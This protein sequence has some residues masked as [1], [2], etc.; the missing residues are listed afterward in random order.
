MYKYEMN[1]ASIMDDTERTRF[2]KQ[3]DR[4]TGGRQTDGQGDTSIPPFNFVEDIWSYFVTVI[5]SSK[6]QCPTHG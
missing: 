3:A 6:W 2:F 5:A 1:L 4:R